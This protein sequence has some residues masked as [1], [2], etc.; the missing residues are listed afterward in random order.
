MMN[1]TAYR[2][3]QIIQVKIFNDQQV[4]IE[5]IFIC[6]QKHHAALA[7]NMNFY[8]FVILCEC[9]TDNF[10][11]IVF[12]VSAFFG[13]T[14][15]N[16][17]LPIIFVILRLSLALSHHHSPHPSI[18][19]F[20]EYWGDFKYC[21]S[22]NQFLYDGK[23][24]YVI[25]DWTIFI[26]SNPLMLWSNEN[27]KWHHKNQNKTVT[28]HIDVIPKIKSRSFLCII[29]YLFTDCLCLCNILFSLHSPFVMFY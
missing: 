18:S 4:K 21:T 19:R 12:H 22:H 13:R 3:P 20:R 17:C 8:Q 29:R 26:N 1:V 27:S 10:T 24:A 11:N 2:L 9:V 25:I 15:K 6:T 7:V 28:H 14:K 23:N 16:M 5:A